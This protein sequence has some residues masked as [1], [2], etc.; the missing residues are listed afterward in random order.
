MGSSAERFARE[1]EPG[2]ATAPKPHEWIA[3]TDGAC[4]GNPGPAGAGFV[5]IEPGGKIHEGFE[6]LGEATN[7]VA[8]LTAVLRGLQGVPDVGA[9]VRVHTD[10][11]YAIGVLQK[12]WKATWATSRTLPRCAALASR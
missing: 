6:Y 11:G 12:G 7:N 9:P 5:V 8:E 3:F 2:S 1:N 10:S 4:S